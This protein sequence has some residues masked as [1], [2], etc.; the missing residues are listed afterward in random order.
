MMDLEPALIY[1]I[2]PQMPIPIFSCRL[3]NRTFY[4]LFLPMLEGRDHL[5]MCYINNFHSVT[6]LSQ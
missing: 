3:I 2:R 6:I 1:Q 4:M 5:V